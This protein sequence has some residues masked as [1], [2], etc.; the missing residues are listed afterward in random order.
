MK[1]TVRRK[2]TKMKNVYK[3]TIAI[4]IV[5]LL[6]VSFVAANNF[7]LM[8]GFGQFSEE[9]KEAAKANMDAIKTAIKNNNYQ[10]WKAAMEEQIAIL[11]SQIT[12][13]NFNA[14]VEKHNE[15]SEVQAK[16]QAAKDAG[17]TETLQQLQEQ[18]GLGKGMGHGMKGMNKGSC[19]M[20]ENTEVE[21]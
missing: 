16:I 20:A 15:M 6:A 10:D 11:E 17:D 5:A 9:D 18:Y 21:D 3:G 1:I 14:L 7:G 13:E 8:N 4:G 12:P 19:P 2:N